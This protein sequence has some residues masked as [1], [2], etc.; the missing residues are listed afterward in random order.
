MPL[1]LKIGLISRRRSL[2]C[3]NIFPIICVKATK[4]IHLRE[5][6]LN[7]FWINNKLAICDVNAL[8]SDYDFLSEDSELQLLQSALRLSSNQLTQ[9]R[10]QLT[11]HLLGRLM[12]QKSSGLTS[13]Y[14]AVDPGKGGALASTLITVADAARRSIAADL[15]MSQPLG[16]SRCHQPR[17]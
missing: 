4:Q 7:Y 6:L 13:P 2:I 15:G 17:W 16:R 14:H 9:D 8:L 10:S 3:G 5:L 11:S 12:F 1:I